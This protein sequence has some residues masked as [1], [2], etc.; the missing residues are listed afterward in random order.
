MHAPLARPPQARP[1]PA[2]GC[3]DRVRE[4]LGFRHPCPRCGARGLR[5]DCR[6]APD[7]RRRA[8]LRRSPT[9]H[10][11]AASLRVG[12]RLHRSGAGGAAGPGG[13]ARPHGEVV[14]LNARA[15]TIAPA[16][17]RG[18]PV[19][20]ALRVPEV[21]DAI[22]RAAAGGGAQRAEFFERVPVVRW[23]EAIVTPIE[24]AGAASAPATLLVLMTFHDLTPLRRVEEMRA[25]FVANASHELRTPL[26]ALSGFIE[27]LQGPARDDTRRARALPR[28]HAGAGEPHG[29]PD[30]RP[31]VALAHRAQRPSASGQGGRSGR[32][33]SARSST[34]CR[35]SRATATSRC[36]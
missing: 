34:G 22:R 4:P 32:R 1:L 25:D 9:S 26:A 35:R 33:S 8:S 28:H 36:A 30:R 5:A 12:D 29:A 19:S 15:S 16:L 20:L 13:R 3:G 14:A 31:A 7:R 23:Y 2:R 11:A 10:D 24:L 21:L 6:G 17:R 27:T 18:E